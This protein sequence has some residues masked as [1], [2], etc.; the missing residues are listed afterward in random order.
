MVEVLTDLPK[1]QPGLNEKLDSQGADVDIA[2][3]EEDAGG[4]SNYIVRATKRKGREPT[5]TDKVLANIHLRD[6]L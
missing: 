1:S 6:T 3:Q 4:W 5:N 2:R